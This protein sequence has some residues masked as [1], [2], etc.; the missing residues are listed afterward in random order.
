MTTVV[1]EVVNV[2]SFLTSM[3][4]LRHTVVDDLDPGRTTFG[5]VTAVVLICIRC[6]VGSDTVRLSG[7][8]LCLGESSK[9]CA[10]HDGRGN[11]LCRLL[12]VVAQSGDLLAAIRL[13]R[14][15]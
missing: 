7:G 11:R 8:V 9:T 13:M 1:G 15:H 5:V 14:C 12:L 6:V 10:K 4:L 3:T 2:E